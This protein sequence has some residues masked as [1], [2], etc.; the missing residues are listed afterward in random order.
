MA[1]TR[2]LLG[3]RAFEGLVLCA[4]LLAPAAATRAGEPVRGVTDSEIVIGTYTD[5]SGVT[6]M[7]GVNNA[8]AIRMAFD[9]QNAKGGINGRKIRY[10]VEDNQYQVPR[11]VQA[12]NKLINRDHVFLM[13]ANGGTPMNNATMPEQLEKGVPNMFPLTSARSMYE[14][15]NRLKFGLAASY[16]D[17]LRA[18]VKYFV[19]QKGKKRVCAMYQDTDFGRDVM[20]GVRAQLKASNLSLV[21]ETT[22]KPTDMDFSAQVA[23]LRDANC[24]LVTLATIT[25][26]TNQIVAAAHKIGWKPD[27]LGSAAVYD[28]AVADVPGNANDGLY[29]VTPILYVGAGDPRP[30]VQEFVRNFRTAFGHDPN[31]AA[32]VG[33]TAANL[34]IEGLK[35]AGR[36]LTLDS[37]IT[38]MESIHDYEDIFGSPKMSFGPHRRQGSNE[39]FLVQVHNGKWMPVLE[40]AVSY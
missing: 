26:D 12:A 27:M 14:P 29:G 38:G 20:D 23:K 21:A 22:H 34:L 15:F 25:R 10:I 1:A 33:W 13:I 11:S 19:E 31:F 39:S 4:A 2:L 37:F 3:R 7:W 36:D 35:A 6:A 18:G 16:Y 40:S 17:Q 24:D 28:N 30:A 32:Q 5:L 9:M 8:D